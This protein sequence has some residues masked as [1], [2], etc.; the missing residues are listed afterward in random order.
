VFSA[1]LTAV[2]RNKLR[3]MPGPIRCPSE[4]P[5]SLRASFDASW[6][7]SIALKVPSG[8]RR[9]RIGVGRGSV[10]EKPSRYSP[11]SLASKRMPFTVAFIASSPLRDYPRGGAVDK[12][13]AGSRLHP[14]EVTDHDAPEPVRLPRPSRHAPGSGVRAALADAARLQ[15]GVPAAAPDRRAAPGRAPH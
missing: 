7:F 1:S 3:P 4:I 12:V 2:H 14:Q 13:G 11:P 9:L 10:L 15:R 8:C 5:S 6:R